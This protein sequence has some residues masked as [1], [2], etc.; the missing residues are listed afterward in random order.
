M[1]IVKKQKDKLGRDYVVIYDNKTVL[2]KF[3]G[4]SNQIKSIYHIFGDLKSPRSIE[5]DFINKDGNEIIANYSSTL[6][7]NFKTYDFVGF[8]S[9]DEMG[10]RFPVNKEK[11]KE[12][13]C[14]LKI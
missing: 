8:S 14:L 3:R 7:F 11:I 1:S 6:G 2:K 13:Y 5:V 4:D 10:I 12:W 9:K